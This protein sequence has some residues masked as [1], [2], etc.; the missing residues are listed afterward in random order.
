MK[1]VDGLAVGPFLCLAGLQCINLKGRERKEGNKT[2]L[3][4]SVKYQLQSMENYLI[5][6]RSSGCS[7]SENTCPWELQV[8]I[9]VFNSTA[10]IVLG[11]TKAE[12]PQQKY[13]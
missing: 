7:V 11:L 6:C 4:N 1:W 13:P 10:L 9:R 5:H 12:T 2:A 8:Y 3:H